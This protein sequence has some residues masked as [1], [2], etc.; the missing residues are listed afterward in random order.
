LGRYLGC[1]AREVRFSAGPNG[2]PKLAAADSDGRSPSFNLTHS[3]GRAL[4]AVSDGRDVGIDLEKVKPDVQAL[5]IARRYFAAAELADI[6]GR[7]AAL[8]AD[9]FYR[10]WVAKEAL[11]KGAGLGLRFPIDEFAVQFDADDAS[12][13]VRIQPPSRLGGDWTLKRLPVES[14][15][16]GALAVRGNDWTLQL[17][18]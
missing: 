2:K 3:Q 5:A 14:G 12:A 9:R 18:S 7:P 11:L 16:A 13:R 4:V 15:W 10:Y 6:E 17:Q 8:Q 1:K